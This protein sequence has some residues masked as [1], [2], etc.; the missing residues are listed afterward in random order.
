[1]AFQVIQPEPFVFAPPEEWPKWIRRF[2]RFRVA[3]GLETKS[4]E[5]Q[6]ST[7]ICCIG[8]DADD[9]LRSFRLSQ[10][11]S[12]KYKMIRN[13]FETHFVKRRNVIF[14]RAKFNQ[15]K[16]EVGES[17]DTFV[18]DLYSLAEHCDYRDL[19][20][21]LNCCWNIRQSSVREASDGCHPH[22][23]KSS[24]FSATVREC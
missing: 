12:K 22:P 23:G 6:I 9:I 5:N 20:E 17:T 16:Q 19:R 7:L 3:T 18:M 11:N 13:T 14:E 2:E 10:E 24:F 4:E 21:E 1:M 15:R 8:D